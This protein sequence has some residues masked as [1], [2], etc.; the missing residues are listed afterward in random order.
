MLNYSLF[1]AVLNGASNRNRT[2]KTITGRQILLTTIVFTTSFFQPF[3][4]GFA[5]CGLEHAIAIKPTVTVNHCRTAF[6]HEASDLT[7]YCCSHI[8]L[9]IPPLLSTPSLFIRLGSA[10]TYKIHS[11]GFEII[12][13][14][15]TILYLVFAEFEEILLTSFD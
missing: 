13:S 8:F 6:L 5:V 12:S 3:R 2:G 14:G 7:L 4:F 1:G 9:G 10:L 15:F 11:S